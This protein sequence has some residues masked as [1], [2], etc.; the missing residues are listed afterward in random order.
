MGI[1]KQCGAEIAD[2]ISFC[3]NCG[4]AVDG[5]EI[6]VKKKKPLYKKW[7]AWLLLVPILFIIFCIIGIIASCHHE[8]APATCTQ[9]QICTKCGAEQGEPLGHDYGEWKEKEAATCA[10]KGVEEAV[11]KTCGDVQTRDIPMLEHTPGEW[12]VAT[13]ATCKEKGKET[14]VCT[15][16][17]ETIERELPLADHIPGEWEITI[18]ATADKQGERVQ[19]CTVCGKTLNTEKF[20]MTAEEIRQAYVAK[21]SPYSYE[22]LARNPEEYKGN[23][24]VLR[25]EVIQVMEDNGEYTLRVNITEGAYFWDDTILVYYEQ[26]NASAPRIL[27]DDIV[28]MYGQLNGMYTYESIF[29]ASITVPLLMAEYIDIQ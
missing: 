18:P 21:C 20:T 12:T 1:C 15:V 29:G 9:P 25:G 11:C 23:Y 13:A 24:A 28:T 8:W 4:A 3:P 17:G 6:K 14:A 16:C 2:D 10:K 22:Q 19:K 27:E 26:N 5:Q 7:W